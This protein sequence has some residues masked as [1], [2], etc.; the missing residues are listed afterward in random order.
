M[1]SETI[2][3]ILLGDRINT[4]NKKSARYRLDEHVFSLRPISATRHPVAAWQYTI[5]VL[6]WFDRSLSRHI[7][8]RAV[9][10]IVDTYH[11][12]DAYQVDR[13]RTAI[14]RFQRRVEDQIRAVIKEVAEAVW[15]P[16][17]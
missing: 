6:R 10:I 9:L 17:R 5:D 3:I 7:N 1:A 13:R 15:F 11:Y 12:T 8:T 2:K 14:T 4:G 16:R